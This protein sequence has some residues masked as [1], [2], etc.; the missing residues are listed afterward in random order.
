MTFVSVTRVLIRSVC[1]MPRFALHAISSLRQYK[2]ASGFSGRLLAAG[3]QIEL[4]PEN[5]T[6]TKAT[7]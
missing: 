5:W 4:L 3:P 1:F 6:L 7:I 2:G